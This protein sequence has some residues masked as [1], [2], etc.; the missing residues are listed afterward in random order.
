MKIDK[1]IWVGLVL[2][3]AGTIAIQ[4]DA[5]YTKTAAPTQNLS[6]SN[7]MS[8]QESDI[9]LFIPCWMPRIIYLPFLDLLLRRGGQILSPNLGIRPSRSQEMID[10]ESIEVFPPTKAGERGM[11]A[12]QVQALQSSARRETNPQPLKK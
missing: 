2:A 4:G 10:P 1:R 6:A 3:L 12:A 5:A 7:A 11:S 9:L 8:D